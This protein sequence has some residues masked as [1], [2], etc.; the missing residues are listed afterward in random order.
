[1]HFTFAQFTFPADADRCAAEGMDAA[2]AACSRPAVPVAWPA[3]AAVALGVAASAT[4]PAMTTGI[5]F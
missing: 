2:G 5:H 1:M 3:V 4:A